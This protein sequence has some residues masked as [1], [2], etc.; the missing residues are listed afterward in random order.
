MAFA[1]S[2]CQRATIVGTPWIVVHVPD[3]PVIDPMVPQFTV[4]VRSVRLSCPE[5]GAA[6]LNHPTSGKDCPWV[7]EGDMY[8]PDTKPLRGLMLCM[9]SVEPSSL[10]H[11]PVGLVQLCARAAKGRLKA[12]ASRMAGISIDFN[13]DFI[14]S[15]QR[16]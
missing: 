6:V 10:T 15:L 12:A 14:D 8:V 9:L 16:E 1:E 7:P 2:R 4:K 13:V 11:L 5:T 3:Q